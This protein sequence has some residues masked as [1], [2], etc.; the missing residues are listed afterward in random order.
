MMRDDFPRCLTEGCEK[1]GRCWA[2]KFRGY[3]DR[4][5]AQIEAEDKARRKQR[6]I[7][8]AESRK[9]EIAEAVAAE[10]EECAKIAIDIATYAREGNGRHE[11]DGQAGSQGAE[12]AANDIA[13]AI[14]M[15][16]KA[17]VR[18][19]EPEGTL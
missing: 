2:G 11:Y 9:R 14:R 7:E 1:R 16:G 15:R 19:D 12:Q 18:G 8:R 6:S 5:K 10:R 13:A 17:N 3:C 4:C